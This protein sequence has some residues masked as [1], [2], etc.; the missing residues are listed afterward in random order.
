VSGQTYY[1]I[2]GGAVINLFSGG[3]GAAVQVT[4]TGTLTSISTT[5][6]SGFP[7]GF[8]GVAKDGEVLID[9]ATTLT[10][11]NG[12]DLTDMVVGDVVK[13]DNAT[14][15]NTYSSGV[16]TT[17]TVEGGVPANI[18][19][20]DTSTFYSVAATSG[21]YIELT[22]PGLNASSSIELLGGAS[23]FGTFTISVNGSVVVP[24]FTGN[25]AETYSLGTA[26]TLNTIRFTCVSGPGPGQSYSIRGVRVNGTLLVDG[27]YSTQGTITAKST[28][29]PFSLTLNNV[30]GTWTSGAS[31]TAVGP[32]S[33]GTGI[34]TITG[35]GTGTVQRSQRASPQARHRRRRHDDVR[36][37][38][39]PACV[40]YRAAPLRHA[41][42]DAIPPLPVTGRLATCPCGP[43][44][45]VNTRG[46]CEYPSGPAAAS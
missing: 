11:T 2:N 42:P 8:Y 43:A 25:N 41:A 46:W 10:L 5:G 31:R 6:T 24:S 28:T 9:G 13:Q 20:G 44:E 4:Y 39:G 19:D 26:A 38:R 23:T 12:T 40:L 15:P 29:S 18:Y 1:Q 36:A 3:S 27:Q 17:S 7:S 32:T 30:L 45:G 21:T 34:I 16:T 35:T 33:T 22:L 37:L 14:G